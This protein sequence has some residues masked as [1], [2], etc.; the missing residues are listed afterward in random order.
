MNARHFFRHLA[1]LIAL[2]IPL[3]LFLPAPAAMA[4]APF[5]PAETITDSFGGAKSVYAADVDGDGDLDVLGA[6]EYGSVSGGYV[7]WW[8]N[9]AGDGTAWTEQIVSSAFNGGNSVYAADVDGDGDLDVLGAAEG[10]DTIAWW[11]NTAGDGTAWTEHIVSSTF[12]GAESVYAADVDGDGDLDVLGAAYTAG[13]IA[14]WENTTGDGSAWTEHI[15][16]S[17]FNGAA[18]VYASDVDGDGDLDV[19]GVAQFDSIVVWWENTAGD[20]SAWTPHDVGGSFITPFSVHAADV[21]GDG[22]VDVL[23]ADF[24]TNEIVWWENMAGNGLVWTSHD[25]G[26]GVDAMSVYAGD[27]DG[28]GDLDVLGTSFDSATVAWW[29]NTAGDGSAWTLH[30]LDSGFGGPK[31][32]Y[33]ADVDG[34]GDLDVLGAAWNAGTIAWWRNETIHRSAAYPPAGM[35]VLSSTFDGVTLA[36]AADVD[37]DGDTDVLGAATLS[38]TIAWWENTSPVG[39]GSVWAQ[40]VISD[41]FD[42]AEHVYAADV[43]GDGDTDVLGAACVAGTIA[44]W[45]NT[46]PV[47]NGSA[48]T[49]HVISDTF[50]YA[51]SVTAADVDGD[52]DTDVLGAAEAAN[53]IAWW[54]NTA[55]DG[56]AW[57]EH[58]LSSTFGNARSATAADV[59]GDGDLDVLGAAYGA[60]TIAWWENT[61]NG[62]FNPI[63]KVVSNTFGGAFDALAAD[64]D[65]DGDMDVLGAAWNAGTIAWW[66]NTAGDGSAWTQRILSSTFAGAESVYAADV[67]GD[68]DMDVLGAAL[69]ADTITWWENTAGDG[70][71]WTQHILSSTFAGAGSVHVADVDGDGDMDVLGSAN[72]ADTIAWWENLGGQ[73]ALAT[74]DSAPAVIISGQAD[75]V[76]KVTM[77]HLGRVGD[78]DEEWATAALLFE[79]EFGYP[80]DSGQANALIESLSVYG[81]DGSGAFEPGADTLV[82]TVDTL[83]LVN[84]IQTVTFADGD[85]NVQVAYGAPRTYFVVVELTLQAWYQ[86]PNHFRVTHLTDPA[87]G[88][89]SSAEDRDH[90]LGLGLEYTANTASGLVSPLVPVTGASLSGLPEAYVDLTWFFT[91]TV[92]PAEPTAPITYTWSPDPLSGQGTAVAAYSWAATGTVT[93]TVQAQN[94]G[95]MAT[96]SFAVQVL[97]N[98][99]SIVEPGVTTTIVYTDPQVVTTTVIIPPDAISESITLVFTPNPTPAHPISEGLTFA[100]HSFDLDAYLGQQ[101]LPGYVFSEP[102]SVSIRYTDEDIAE[103]QEP[104]LRLYYWTGSAWADGASTCSPPSTYSHDLALNR[105][106]V[107][108]CHLTEWNIQGP[109]SLHIIYLPLIVKNW[110]LPPNQGRAASSADPP[111]GG[112][113]TPPR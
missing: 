32:V 54:E 97:A 86:L 36:H 84:G 6:A 59:D 19:L 37:G 76:L 2:V 81:D 79:D 39:N 100:N 34:D 89:V 71:A 43:D 5:S 112:L 4:D 109:D 83:T 65:G 17:T 20:G 70:T 106:A 46:S 13:T 64:L 73:F 87:T 27:V 9:T 40:H 28:D 44:W 98:I 96:A 42:G 85:P 75:D 26:T 102:I 60:D 104:G 57:T 29:E 101:L 8:E 80:L 16:S 63:P 49:Q 78:G 88:T 30:I 15:L 23:S 68:G 24:D 56:S 45:E 74:A 90:D 7:I 69:F 99:T 51:R 61:G 11:E 105:I 38:N 53:T 94:R 1:T 52:G 72:D 113:H 12:D 21:D 77:T 14:W 82:T 22:D 55:G 10:I 95:G 50:D 48:W 67:D 18:S 35:H 108:I 58:V 110:P 66:E 103:I 3:L 91:A 41:T 111:A 93:L 107:E 25:V 62:A 33:G 92:E 47:G 31:G